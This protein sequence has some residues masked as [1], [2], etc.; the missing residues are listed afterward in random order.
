MIQ[1]K[2][3]VV[4][5][6]AWNKLA[7]MSSSSTR[8]ILVGT[9]K[10]IIF[11]TCLEPTDEFFRR[12]EKYLTQLFSLHMPMPITG[13]H[14]ERFPSN[15]RKYLIF[16][17]TPTR[18]YHF[19]GSVKYTNT[20]NEST[21]GEKALF[22]HIFAEYESNPEFQELPS[23]LHYSCMLFFNRFPELQQKGVPQAFA[24]LTGAGVYHGKLDFTE[25]GEA[26]DGPS[27]VPFPPTSYDEEAGHLVTD[28]P[29]SFV[30]TEFHF[31]LL[32]KDHVRAICRLNDKM[33]YEEIIPLVSFILLR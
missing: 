14:I 2:G 22:E 18:F 32:Y 29:I 9:D 8:E 5:S 13:L 27:L 3:I 6:I 33:V 4:T 30:I 26:I 31:I 17:S 19:V 25:N 20:T 23:D 24:W 12:E 11:E 15:R 10:G 16:I 28:I 7:D 21:V 1:Q